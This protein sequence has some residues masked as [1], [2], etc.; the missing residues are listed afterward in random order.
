MIDVNF[1]ARNFKPRS[2]SSI[3]AAQLYVQMTS[4]FNRMALYPFRICHGNVSCQLRDLLGYYL[5]SK[6][7]YKLKWIV[8][9]ELRRDSHAT[10]FRTQIFCEKQ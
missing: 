5:V 4:N 2:L 10:E 6:R 9:F 7:L 8:K 3:L 1:K